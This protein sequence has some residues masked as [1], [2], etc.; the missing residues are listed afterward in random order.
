MNCWEFKKCGREDGGA[1]IEELGACPATPENGK[2]CA[3]VAGTLC[4]GEVQ[5]TFAMK[6]SNC[7]LCDFYNSPH[8]DK[9]YN[10]NNGTGTH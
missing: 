6:L 9:S 3:R 7:M 4:G 1:K 8:Y 2:H 10:G 5:G